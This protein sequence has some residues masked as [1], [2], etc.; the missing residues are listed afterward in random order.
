MLLIGTRDITV[1]KTVK[2]VTFG[3]YLEEEMI[4]NSVKMNF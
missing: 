4:L 3:A 2:S 1:N